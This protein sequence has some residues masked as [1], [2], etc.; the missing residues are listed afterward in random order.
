M[1]TKFQAEFSPALAASVGGVHEELIGAAS[2]AI[3]AATHYFEAI[4]PSMALEAIWKFVGVA[5]KYID[6]TQPWAMAKASSPDLPHTLWSL[7]ASLWLIGRLIA[8]VMPASAAIIRDWIGDPGT[9]WPVH[10]TACPP[11]KIKLGTPLFPRLDA[12]QQAAIIA[13][14]IPADA[15]KPADAAPAPAKKPAKAAAVP[16]GPAASIEYGDFAKLDLRVGKIVTAAAIPK[17]DKLL[18]LTIDLGEAAPRTIVSGLALRYKPDE[19]VGRSVI[20]VANLTPRKLGGLM[21]AG[22]VL[23]GG[24]DAILGLSTI[25]E[26]VPPGTRVK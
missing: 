17:Y 26:S 2:E 19:I 9:E 1:I 21:S 4:K 13:K 23:S 20:V 12:A 5:N 25:D 16:E 10:L 14:L 24:D 6:Q 22:M 15:L 7:G 18:H 3:T 8:P 11:L